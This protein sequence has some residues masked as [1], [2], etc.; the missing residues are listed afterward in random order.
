MRW[1]VGTQ[2]LVV[3]GVALVAPG[4]LDAG[5]VDTGLVDRRSRARRP[6]GATAGA[7]RHGGSSQVREP[8][9]AP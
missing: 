2:S 1:P 5:L 4:L 6:D 7:R 9:P 8:V 3:V